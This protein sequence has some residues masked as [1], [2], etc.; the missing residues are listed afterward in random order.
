MG[1]CS[2]RPGPAPPLPPGAPRDAGPGGPGVFPHRI[3]RRYHSL[4]GQPPAP[5]LVPPALRPG[6]GRQ[7]RR[8]RERAREEGG[9]ERG[10]EAASPLKAVRG[11]SPLPQGGCDWRGPPSLRGRDI[12]AQQK[13]PAAAAGGHPRPWCGAGPAGSPARCPSAAAPRGTAAGGSPPPFFFFFAPP[14]L[15]TLLPPFSFLF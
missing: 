6:R 5:S 10:R 7:P 1:H 9:K 13:A 4:T 3:S 11:R 15:F 8:G 14:L 12:A 2:T